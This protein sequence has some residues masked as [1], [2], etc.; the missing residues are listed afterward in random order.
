[1]NLWSRKLP[2][3]VRFLVLV[4]LASAALVRG[5]VP[6]GYMLASAEAPA[7]R[8]VV[9]EMCGSHDQ[10]ATV[11]NLDTGEAVSQSE[12]GEERRS[13]QGQP[14]SPCVFAT[15]SCL[16]ALE[17]FE[18][19]PRLAVSALRKP[20]GCARG[21]RPGPASPPPPSTGPPPRI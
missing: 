15:A 18:D 21:A 4:A 13:A 1:M 9:I 14:H 11:I 10:P 19:G 2:L 8:F 12:P 3:A 20:I 17:T 5:V 7:G 6:A 16:A